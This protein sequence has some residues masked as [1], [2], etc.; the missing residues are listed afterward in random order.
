MRRKA[1]A[2]E[3]AGLQ[4]E[5]RTRG[6]GLSA[7]SRVRRGVFMSTLARRAAAPVFTIAMLSSAALI[8]MVQP[9]FARLT[10][11]LLGGSPAVWNTAMVF[12]QTALLVGYAYAHLLTRLS[13][14]RTQAIVHA[15]VLGLAALALPLHVTGLLG[16]PSSTS[17]QVWLMGAL[18][19][20]VGAPYAA[21]CATAPLLQAWYARTGRGDAGDPYYLYAASNIGSLGGL[22]AYPLLAEPFL[23]LS[24]Q[25][26]GWSFGFGVV[27]A[28]II[29]SGLVAVAAKG[30][31]LPKPIG[32]A[33][34]IAWRERGLW[35]AAAAVPSA[36]L[37]GATQH[38]STDVASAP[39]LWVV[40]LALYLITF[41]VAFSKTG[42]RFAG[43]S[44]M[45]HPL[46]LALLIFA[47]FE[48]GDWF[49]ILGANLVCFFLS[50]LVC[51]YFLAERRPEAAR[52]TEFYLF[53]SLGGALGGAATAL[54]APVVFNGIYE[55]PLALAAVALFLPRSGQ[56]RYAGM[57]MGLAASA[58]AMLLPMALL[59]KFNPPYVALFC[60][61]FGAAAGLICAGLLARHGDN[62]AERRLALGFFG[63]TLVF[64]AV[65]ALFTVRPT[66]LFLEVTPEGGG[67]TLTKLATLPGYVLGGL[68]L[69]T[70]MFVVHALMRKDAAERH[71]VTIAG[72][73]GAG[74]C[75]MGLGLAVYGT[76]LTGAQLT[77]IATV[78]AAAGVIAA[79]GRPFLMAFV[80]LAAF[81][82]I[83]L[84]EARGG[85]RIFQDR[86][87]FGVLRVEDIPDPD[88]GAGNLRMLYHGTTIHGAQLTGEGNTQRP[89]TYYHPLTSLGEATARAL[90]VHRPARLALIGLGSGATACL[91]WPGDEL[92]IFE[93][94]PTVVRLSTGPGAVFT[95]ENECTPNSRVVLGDAR[96]KISEEPSGR[97][98][99]VV[100][101]A[102]SSDAIP[103]HLLT[104]EA[105]ATYRDK[106]GPTGAVILHL[107]NRNLA[108]VFEA[109]RVAREL[110]L[111][112]VWRT[113]DSVDAAG[114]LGFGGLPATTMVLARTPEAL[115]AMRFHNGAWC[116]PPQVEGA[117]WSDDY[118]NIVRALWDH[119]SGRED[120]A[121]RDASRQCESPPGFLEANVMLEPAAQS[122]AGKAP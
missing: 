40:P 93:I 107:S 18:A 47:F 34:P 2:R 79:I 108:L 10:T 21:A 46:A 35:M 120:R 114:A 87:F 30:E 70:I 28:L 62:P 110:G 37:L 94:D 115:A 105:V 8:F 106:V 118:I 41:V 76:S 20:S 80:A 42:A 4:N 72:G 59:Y 63:V 23:R 109:S 69:L 54:L 95:Y 61:A 14:V 101:D 97:F 67:E 31:A 102:F 51:H 3:R 74:F 5:K 121:T 103:A 77:L 68:C 86:S 22:L 81:G 89:L 64:A 11:P 7:A 91:I 39:F 71:P 43:M 38:I 57:G 99:V 15:V 1:V 100:V 32:V 13:N 92:T 117:A 98:D 111:A 44:R 19:L 33:A 82:V 83:T 49:W 55:Y 96:L 56:V 116:V 85:T 48:H 65:M 84:N 90:R 24:Q 78:V 66:L 16:P 75:A 27:G 6:V 52:L 112:A 9:L 53:V 45:L 36:L 29:L 58:A 50:G 88:P 12:F 113:S 25:Q 60:S 104:R 122:Q 17:P 26:L 73:I 119:A